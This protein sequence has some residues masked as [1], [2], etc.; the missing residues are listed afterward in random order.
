MG[1]HIA[2][3]NQTLSSLSTKF[4]IV[5][6]REAIIEWERECVM[7]QRK[8]VKAA[9]QII[10]AFAKVAVDF[11][12]PFMTMQ[13]RGRPRQEIFVFIYMSGFKSSTFRDGL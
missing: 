7:C 5:A 12:G 1:N 8:K 9:Q 11:G 2:G 10:R 13:G 3:T 6:A 4:W